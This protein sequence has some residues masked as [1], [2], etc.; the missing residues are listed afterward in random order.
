MIAL[1]AQDLEFHIDIAE[2][3]DQFNYFKPSEILGIGNDLSPWY[4]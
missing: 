3:D 1:D 2:L 4:M